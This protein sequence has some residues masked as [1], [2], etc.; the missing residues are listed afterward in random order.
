[1]AMSFKKFIF[2]FTSACHKIRQAYKNSFGYNIKEEINKVKQICERIEINEFDQISNKNY[3]N[4]KCVLRAEFG[5]KYNKY[6][7]IVVRSKIFYTN[8]PHNYEKYYKNINVDESSIIKKQNGTD[9]SF[10]LTDNIDS[11]HPFINYLKL[12]NDKIY[13]IKNYYDNGNSNKFHIIN[14]A[15]FAKNISIKEMYLHYYFNNITNVSYISLNNNSYKFYNTV[16]NIILPNYEIITI[17]EKYNPIDYNEYSN[18]SLKTITNKKPHYYETFDIYFENNY[19]YI[20]NFYKNL[21]HIKYYKYETP[22]Q[23]NK[24]DNNFALFCLKQTGKDKYNI[25][26]YLKMPKSDITFDNMD[27][28]SVKILEYLDIPKFLFVFDEYNTY[29]SYYNHNKQ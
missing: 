14:Y 6:N 3:K 9:I 29:N 7:K 20:C 19:N 8:T 17:D 15:I 24:F 18:V 16:G 12:D 5:D 1:M 4:Y 2:D 23:F 22:D 25:A 13:D 21:N 27:I 11:N 10:K 26:Q 28:K